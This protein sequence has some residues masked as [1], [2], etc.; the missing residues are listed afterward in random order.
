MLRQW[1]TELSGED[2]NDDMDLGD[3]VIDENDR[4]DDDEYSCRSRAR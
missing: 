4:N 1:W 2:D 3:N